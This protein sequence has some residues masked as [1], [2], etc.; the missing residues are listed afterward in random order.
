[1]ELSRARRSDL[2]GAFA[3]LLDQFPAHTGQLKIPVRTPNPEPRGLKLF[4]QARMKHRLVPRTIRFDIAELNRFPSVLFLVE[5]RVERITVKVRVRIALAFNG[6][7]F[8]VKKGGVHH[9]AR[10]PVFVGSGFTLLVL[11]AKPS[12]HADL[13]SGHCFRR[14]LAQH[15]FHVLIAFNRQV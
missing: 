15:P 10:S 1:M 9:I 14:G 6:S 8:T 11:A 7:C 5:G 4:R 3:E 12:L 13:D 2:R